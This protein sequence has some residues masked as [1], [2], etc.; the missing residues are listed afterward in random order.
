MVDEQAA[1][2]QVTHYINA[3]L[4]EVKNLLPSPEDFEDCKK[5]IRRL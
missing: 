4:K 1:R 3:R 2:R 5:L